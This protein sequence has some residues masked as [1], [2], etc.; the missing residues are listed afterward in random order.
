M[1]PTLSFKF[2]HFDWFDIFHSNS[3]LIDSY[4]TQISIF[5]FDIL[6]SNLIILI[7]SNIFTQIARFWSNWLLTLKFQH[8]DRFLHFHSS[9][10]I[11]I[12]F[13][14]FSQVLKLFM[15]YFF[16]QIATFC[17]NWNFA[18]KFPI[19]LK[20]RKFQH[21]LIVSFLIKF[22]IWS[23]PSFTLKLQYFDW[24][25]SNE[26]LVPGTSH[27][28]YYM[29]LICNSGLR[30]VAYFQHKIHCNLKMLI[31]LKFG[32]QD[33]NKFKFYNCKN[34]FLVLS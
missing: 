12:D 9:F 19:F 31:L 28:H 22:S 7:D 15:N 26:E 13:Y 2:Q 32:V 11:L 21:W 17:S 14:L 6:H 20:D 27:I 1:I 30:K 16:T 4:F 24:F 29:W 3:T 8:F 23:I 5:W 25:D 10:N 18:L 33:I 34:C